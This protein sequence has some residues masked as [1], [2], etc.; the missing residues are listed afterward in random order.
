M[1]VCV[2]KGGDIMKS[3]NPNQIQLHRET[4]NQIFF[5]SFSP[6]WPKHQ[7]RLVDS[8]K[9]YSGDFFKF[10]NWI[11][12]KVWSIESKGTQNQNTIS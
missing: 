8:L 11:V 6:F 1:H 9:S 7:I 2:E 3:E 12:Y 4:S 10:S 5:F